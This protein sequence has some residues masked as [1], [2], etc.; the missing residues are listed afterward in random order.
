MQ[1]K[2]S[3]T[4]FRG[5][6]PFSKPHAPCRAHDQGQMYVYQVPL[7]QRNDKFQPLPPRVSRGRSCSG[8]A[9]SQQLRRNASPVVKRGSATALECNVGKLAARGLALS[10]AYTGEG[11]DPER[12]V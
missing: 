3:D 8:E 1:L 5:S 12:N 9:R 7:A 10:K 2:H 6:R 11:G 4:T